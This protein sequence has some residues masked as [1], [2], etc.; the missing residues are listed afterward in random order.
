ML[1][2]GSV[3]ELDINR[4]LIGLALILFL[5]TTIGLVA[6]APDTLTEYP[7]CCNTSM[8]YDSMDNINVTS[9]ITLN[10]TGGS[11]YEDFT[12][13]TESDAFGRISETATRVTFTS[14]D[15]G[16][17]NT[18]LYDTKT[19]DLLAFD[20]KFVCKITSVPSSA[21]TIRINI[22][23]ITN[24]LDDYNDNKAASKPQFGIQLRS[25]S[26]T[27]Q[28]NLLLYE[29]YST[30]LYTAGASAN[31]LNVNTA[32]YVNL[33]KSGTSLTLKVDNDADFSSPITSYSLTL[34][35]NHNLPYLMCPQSINLAGGLATSGY[36]EYMDTGGTSPGTGYYQ[37]TEVTDLSFTFDYVKLNAT[38]NSGSV[39][40]RASG[41][42]GTSWGT[43][44][45]I[46][47]T[48]HRNYDLNGDSLIYQVRLNSTV[49]VSPIL[50]SLDIVYKY[51]YAL[52]MFTELL[53]GSGAFIGHIVIIVLLMA[54][55]RF[56]GGIGGFITLIG[57]VG[58]MLLVF[59]TMPVDNAAY[60][61]VL[62]YVA[63]AFISVINIGG[64]GRR[65]RRR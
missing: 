23:T 18:F 10:N 41:N 25:W 22:M 30:S 60:L 27:T 42:G 34:H 32:Y 45:S 14:L 17:A 31:T 37:S 11:A 12:A 1:F 50:Y 5:S 47:N 54:I 7:D 28:Y 53:W 9:H 4:G 16:D 63:V 46:T 49:G 44:I 61:M 55:K 57:S 36:C 58:M 65:Y 39:E 3:H 26:S 20:I 24:T 64:T 51:D 48:D 15:R 40:F 6:A 52:T 2:R 62:G 56:F 13:W 43:W 19:G 21:T 38:L 59:N 8:T 33:V 29:T 35:A